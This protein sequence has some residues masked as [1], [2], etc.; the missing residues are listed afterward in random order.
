MLM[1]M[2]MVLMVIMIMVVMLM[3]VIMMTMMIMAL[4]VFAP[5]LWLPFTF[6][7]N[8]SGNSTIINKYLELIDKRIANLTKENELLTKLVDNATDHANNLKNTS[9]FLQSL[10]R[11]PQKYAKKALDA[12]D[13]YK[14]VVDTVHEVLKYAQEADGNGGVA[15]ELVTSYVVC[16][17]EIASRG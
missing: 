5:C 15:L 1:V 12:V 13:A 4:L 9:E 16:F 2:M 14:K 8:I 11:D 3:L 10:L 6:G 17:K 7:Q